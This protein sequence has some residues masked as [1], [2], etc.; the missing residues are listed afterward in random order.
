M[1]LTRTILVLVAAGLFSVAQHFPPLDRD[2]PPKSRTVHQLSFCMAASQGISAKTSIPLFT[3]DFESPGASG[4]A[5]I[6]GK[7][8]ANFKNETKLRL[9]SDVP[10][11]KHRFKLLLDRPS[12]NTLM[13]SHDNFKYCRD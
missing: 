6:D 12:Q 8:V 3:F 7:P 9:F 11:G 5:T 1:N 4:T 2:N 10:A 13:L